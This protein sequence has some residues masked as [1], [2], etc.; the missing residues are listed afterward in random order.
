MDFVSNQ[1]PQ[2]EAMLKELGIE[3]PEELFQAIPDYLKH[4]RPTLEDGLSEYEGLKWME[5]IAAQN[6]YPSFENYLGAGAYE[7]HV[8]ALVGAI[9]SK[10]EFL[11]SYTPY[12]PEASQGMLQA[13]FEFQ[14][15]ICALTGLDVAN[16]SVYDG[17][18][19]CA[20]AILMAI[21]YQKTRTKVLIAESIH[22]HY[23]GVIDQ[24]LRHLQIEVETI[25]FLQDGRLDHEQMSQKL[26]DQ[27]AAILVQSPNFFG[28]IEEVK[29]SSKLAKQTGA[30]IILCANPLA[31]GLL[32]SAA[33]VG[34]DMAVGDCQPLG[35]SLQFGGP[36]VG[37]MACRQE[38]M[39]QL[40]G[41]L[42]GETVDTQG[43]RGFVLTLQ[44]RE[45][46]IRR[47]KATSNICTN[48]ALAA[49]ASLVAMLWY[50]PKGLH[51]L[52]LTNFQK[53]NYLKKQLSVVGLKSMGLAPTFNEFVIE[54]DQPVEEVLS[55][56]RSQ[57]VEPGLDLNR[58]FPSL[59]HHLLV[60]VTEAKS[61]EQLDRYVQI[62]KG[63]MHG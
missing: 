57:G 33:D 23:R 61:Q 15:A 54:L 27:V 11:T 7:H 36:Y 63:L 4:P 38:L 26:N 20:E 14:S 44:A 25:P 62:A 51:K 35:L 45:Q 12:Q 17:A 30:L 5:Q 58:Y 37:Y 18:A 46:H 49:L 50:G 2:I 34:A 56:F 43:K 41:R 13:I 10:S 1:L 47:E 29:E 60:A 39:R 22:P 31:Y 6:T 21:R 59:T 52:A 8:P 3:S 32:A 55:Y 42:V 9:C 48:Q 53:A 24:Y 19:A 40:P 16:A 28:V